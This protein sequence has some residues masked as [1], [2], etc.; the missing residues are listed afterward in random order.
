MEQREE[1]RKYIQV[2]FHFN[3]AFCDLI[4]GQEQRI[5][6]VEFLKQERAAIGRLFSVDKKQNLLF[7][8]DLAHLFPTPCFAGIQ[9]G[10]A[11]VLSFQG[12]AEV[13][14]KGALFA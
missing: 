14:S 1:N 8:L 11:N 12:I 10:F 4:K 7:G 3:I 6:F 5:H 2:D 9:N 13:R